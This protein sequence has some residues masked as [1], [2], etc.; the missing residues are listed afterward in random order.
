MEIEYRMLDISPL[1]DIPWEKKK[2]DIGAIYAGKNFRAERGI[3]CL[4]LAV[5]GQKGAMLSSA[6]E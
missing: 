3:V 2:K 4:H 1:Y 5:P 6:L